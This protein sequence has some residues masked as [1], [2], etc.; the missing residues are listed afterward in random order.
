MSLEHWR[1]LAYHIWAKF[2]TAENSQSAYKERISQLEEKLAEQLWTVWGSTAAMVL[3]VLISSSFLIAKRFQAKWRIHKRN[4]YE[5]CVDVLNG[6]HIDREF[7]GTRVHVQTAIEKVTSTSRSL[8]EKHPVIFIGFHGNGKSSTVSA[9]HKYWRE[10]SGLPL[11]ETDK[12]PLVGEFVKNLTVGVEEWTSQI[13]IEVG[14]GAVE[15]QAILFDTAGFEP[16][17]DTKVISECKQ[18]LWKLPGMT[19]DVLRNRLMFVLVASCNGQSFRNLGSFQMKNQ[20]QQ[21]LREF[22]Q[23][24]GRSIHL[25][26]KNYPV[27]LPVLTHKDLKEGSPKNSLWPSKHA[28]SFLRII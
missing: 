8:I 2:E 19:E 7:R 22:L 6:S 23:T 28:S 14:N 24:V 21:I 9:L 5:T 25:S 16:G 11:L 3:V 17:K 20:F 12:R 27:I 26:E 18:A 15:G 10:E 13:S 4:S 1:D